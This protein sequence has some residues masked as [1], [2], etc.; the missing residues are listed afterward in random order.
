MKIAIL[1]S[2]QIGT[3]LMVKISKLSEFEISLVAG[4]RADSPGL[5]LAKSM[6]IPISTDGIESILALADLDV[7]IDCTTATDHIDHWNLLSKCNLHVIDMTPAK[8]GKIYVPNV[9][10]LNYSSVNQYFNLNMVTCGG[11][12]ASPIVAAISKICRPVRV[13][14]ASNIASLSAGPA[15][16]AN[17]DEYI[18]TTEKVLSL[19]SGCEITKA[20]LVLNPATPP[21]TMQ[22]TIFVDFGVDPR[23]HINDLTS[24]INAAL[25][26][27]QNYV[28]G[29]RLLSHPV[30][31]ESRLSV[32]L[33]VKGNGD[34]LPPYSGNLD[35]INA[36]AIQA[37]Q[38][39]SEFES[40]R[41]S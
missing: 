18:F 11:Q 1:G 31:T 7:V 30:F 41:A 35:I 14:I 25:R 21:I 34:Y 22:T 16:R 9:L 3:D 13:E 24:A 39:L 28:P 33:Q 17:I 4:R 40:R 27:M 23:N 37:L 36:A 2:G 8:I 19:V 10:E 32:T 20:I 29:T 5:Q 12:S 15:T 26:D 38:S 6:N